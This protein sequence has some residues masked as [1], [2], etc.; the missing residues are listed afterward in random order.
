MQLLFLGILDGY[1]ERAGLR[2]DREV[3]TG[4]GPVDFTITGN[5]RVRVLIE[6][7]KLTHGKFWHGLQVQTPL[8]MRGQEVDHTIF[9]VIRDSD[10]PDM[11][12]RWR[13][14]RDEASSVREETGLTIEIE[15]I[16]VLPRR[17]ASKA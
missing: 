11:R 15:Q 2:L 4:R 5:R 13:K 10:T 8:Y 1:C 17:S 3:E 9:L 16:D 14:L 6:M 7:K 12:D